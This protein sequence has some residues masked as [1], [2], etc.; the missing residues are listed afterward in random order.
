MLSLVG[1]GLGALVG[2]PLGIVSARVRA[3]RSV[4]IPVVSIVQT[5]PSLA[6]FGLMTVPLVALGLPSIGTLP[7]LI[8]L[9]LYAL[10][11]IVRN[12]YLGIIGVDPAIVDA[13]QGM[14]MSR[15]QLL[16]RVE[17]P[18][19]L[20]LVLEGLR[21]ALV[22]TVGIAAVMAIADAQDLGTLVFLAFGSQATDLA[23]LGALP[24][25]VLAVLGDQGMRVIERVVVSPGIR[26]G[27]AA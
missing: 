1:M 8:A 21:S 7:T 22:L 11:P 2:V 24:M 20:P 4:A 10:L 14:G 19:A 27:S 23:L 13:G 26:G 15:W 9:T 16:L 3:V 12:T 17:M 18:L 6:L 5:V 25:V